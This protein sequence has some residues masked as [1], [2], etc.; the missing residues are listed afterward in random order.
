MKVDDLIN[1]F[2]PTVFTRRKS[3]VLYKL[4]KTFAEQF[5]S[6]DNAIKA[7]R[8]TFQVDTAEG[9]DLEKI[10][11]LFGLY[12]GNNESDDELRARIIAYWTGA[13]GCGTLDSIKQALQQLSNNIDV[14]DMTLGIR[15]K[16]IG[17]APPEV[18]QKIRQIVSAMKP[19][20]VAFFQD[21]GLVVDESIKIDDEEL[22]EFVTLLFFIIEQ[23]KVDSEYMVDTITTDEKKYFKIDDSAFSE[24][25][26]IAK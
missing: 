8:K 11:E 4:L 18:V 21:V 5:D 3:S 1:Y 10:A 12:R 9:D 25:L 26:Y 19:V 22:V 15:F 16:I 24:P 20:G 7:L 13:L 14:Q 2:A 17:E 6:V 23:H